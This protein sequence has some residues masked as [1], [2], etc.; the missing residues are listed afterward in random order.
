MSSTINPVNYRPLNQLDA[1]G[2]VIGDSVD[3]EAFRGEY[4]GN[5]LIYKGFARPGALEGAN[6][7]QIAFIAYDGSGNVLS[8]TWPQNSAGIASNDY[9]F[10]WTGRAGYTYS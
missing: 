5:N 3:D 10:N 6:V 4:A 8:I 9:Q 7:W 2:R 1:Q